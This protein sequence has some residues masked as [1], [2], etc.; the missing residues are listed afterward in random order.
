[1]F[2]RALSILLISTA[3]TL[4]ANAQDNQ[5]PLNEALQSVPSELTEP[6]QNAAQL[7]A[8][9]EDVDVSRT[10][11]T[12][13]ITASAQSNTWNRAVVAFRSGEYE[14]A[15][16]LFKSINNRVQVANLNVA[17]QLD[18][19]GTDDGIGASASIFSSLGSIGER[20][21]T[22][23]GRRG[24]RTRITGFR[25]S[26][27]EEA[28]RANHAVGASLLK[29]GEYKEAKRFFS[30]AVGADKYNHDARLRL[31]LIALVEG[32]TRHARR[33]LRQLNGFCSARDCTGTDELSVAVQTL[34]YFVDEALA[35]A[36]S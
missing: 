13:V 29:Q 3:C 7:T 33:R 19:L 35:E 21:E 26:F 11:D 32:R 27:Q 15:E 1:M 16:R 5:A 6:E 9:G 31:G 8:P 24:A 2:A 34:Q 10:L 28:S 25:T 18:P 30:A 23:P 4:G 22:I 36:E 17:G 14:L 20:V 12:I